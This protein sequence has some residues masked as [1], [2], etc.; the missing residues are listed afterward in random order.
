MTLAILPLA[1]WWLTADDSE[2]RRARRLL[3]VT[4]ATLAGIH[5]ALHAFRR[6][7]P[8]AVD[9]VVQYSALKTDLVTS[10]LDREISADR[11][12][13]QD[14]HELHAGLEY[15][16]TG[17]AKTPGVRVGVWYD[18]KH[19]IEY[20]PT[21]ERSLDDELFSAYLPAGK[22]LIHVTFGAGFPVSPQFEING[23][24][25]VS[26]RTRVGSVSLVVRLK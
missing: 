6:L 17:V 26:S 20:R 8:A 16:F 21:S 19:S 24:A 1:W 5:L 18:P 12:V 7:S 11:F 3:A 22:N 25:D 2:R 10:Q 15:V 4:V 9:I 14:G 23:A 13:I